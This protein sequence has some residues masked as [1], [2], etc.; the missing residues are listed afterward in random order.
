MTS[1]SEARVL[2]RYDHTGHVAVVTGGTKGIGRAIAESLLA[3]G[4]SVA[5]AARDADTGRAVLDEL[6]AGDAATFIPVDVTDQSSCEALIDRVVDRFGYIDILVNNAGGVG[7]FLPIAQMTDDEWKRTIDL[8]LSST[9]WCTRRALPSMIERGWG[10]IVTISS[11]EAIQPMAAFSHYAASKRATHAFTRSLC[12]EVGPLGITAN[13]LCPGLVRTYMVEQQVPHACAALGI[14]EQ[15]W[16]EMMEDRCPIKRLVT[17]EEIAAY[18]GFLFTDAGAAVTG[19]ILSI[20]GG[21]SE[22]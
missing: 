21:L 12:H 7:Q 10:R 11:M 6:G 16:Y 5:L 2:N 8:N 19:Q 14:T 15:Q 4:A 22:H 17:A 13:V 3:G 20:D 9:F 18:A 1:T